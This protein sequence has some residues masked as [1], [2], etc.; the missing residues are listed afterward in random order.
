M[1]SIACV[2]LLSMY[3]RGQ[4]QSRQQY[5]N[6][7]TMRNFQSV[8]TRVRFLDWNTLNTHAILSVYQGDFLSFLYLVIFSW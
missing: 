5:S 4:D 8:S 2:I 6:K 3:Y 7:G 1:A